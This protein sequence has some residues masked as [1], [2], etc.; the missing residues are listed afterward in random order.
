MNFALREALSFDTK[1][2]VEAAVIVIVVGA[3]GLLYARR[4]LSPIR[5]SVAA[6]KRFVADAAHQLRSKGWKRVNHSSSS[7]ISI[8]ASRNFFE[9]CR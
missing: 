3:G 1:V 6:Q 7:W 9:S 2:L 5:E 8:L 4:T